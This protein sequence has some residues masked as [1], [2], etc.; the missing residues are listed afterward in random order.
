MKWDAC[1]LTYVCNLRDFWEEIWRD[2]GRDLAQSYNKNPYTNR[3]VLKASRQHKTLKNF[4]Y[5]T[6]ADRLRTVS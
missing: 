3:Q 1:T 6:I 5:T 2:E 4:E